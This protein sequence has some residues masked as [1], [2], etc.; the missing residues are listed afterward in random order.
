MKHVILNIISNTNAKIIISLTAIGG[1]LQTISR[2]S[3]QLDP[4]LQNDKDKSDDIES[5]F[6]T[7]NRRGKSQLKAVVRFLSKNGLLS[8]IVVGVSS[9]LLKE[10]PLKRIGQLLFPIFDPKSSFLRPIY[11]PSD[12]TVKLLQNLQE[13][14][15]LFW[16][17]TKKTIKN[18]KDL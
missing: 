2:K 16:A 14:A 6:N 18:L 11:E 5:E 10:V 12:I 17:G 15:K 8:G 7:N 9:V 1:L 13:M 4:E 3:Q